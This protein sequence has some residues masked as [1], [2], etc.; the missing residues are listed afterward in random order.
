MK[1]YQQLNEARTQGEWETFEEGATGHFSVVARPS[2]KDHGDIIFD[3]PTSWE[4]SM[5]R[6]QANAQYT[7][8]AV[9]NLHHLA[10]A[11]EN[12][13]KTFTSLHESIMRVYGWVDSHNSALGSELRTIMAELLNRKDKTNEALSRIS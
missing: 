7:A 11:L 12:D 3:A 4:A 2:P 6:W 8:L 9:N 1:L 5:R 13:N 10:E